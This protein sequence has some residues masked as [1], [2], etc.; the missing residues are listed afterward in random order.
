VGGRS[1]AGVGVGVGGELGFLAHQN[2]LLFLYPKIA[3][4]PFS[5][6]TIPYHLSRSTWL[7]ETSNIACSHKPVCFYIKESKHHHRSKAESEDIC[8]SDTVA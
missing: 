5:N 1:E 4:R 7:P 6:S 8:I 2:H 3:R